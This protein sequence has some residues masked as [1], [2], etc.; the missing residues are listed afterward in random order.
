MVG[1]ELTPFQLSMSPQTENVITM[2]P[3]AFMLVTAPSV[4]GSPYNFECRGY[5][6]FFSQFL[7]ESRAHNGTKVTIIEK[8]H[9]KGKKGGENLPLQKGQI[10][11][12]GVF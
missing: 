3:R 8:K 10:L 9:R 7:H 5:C 6:S 1:L 12:F 2:P 11:D 4:V